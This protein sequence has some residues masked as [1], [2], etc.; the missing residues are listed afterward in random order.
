MH[1]LGI[2]ATPVG[3]VERLQITTNRAL[4][5]SNLSNSGPLAAR[6]ITVSASQSQTFGGIDFGTS[7]A[8]CSVIDSQDGREIASAKT[9]YSSSKPEELA[10]S[11]QQALFA[12]LDAIPAELKADMAAIAID[13]TSATAILFDCQ[14]GS[15]LA[16][17]KLYN[18]A[19]SPHIVDLV[20]SIA[21]KDHTT[22]AATSTL[23][24]LLTWSEAGIWQAA[25]AAGGCPV[26]LHQADWLGFLLHGQCGITDWNNALK[27]G[28]DPEIELYPEWMTNKDFASV[29]PKTVVAPGALV[30]PVSSKIAEKTG[31]SQACVVCGGT[32]DS[33]AAFLAAGVDRPGQAVTSLGSTLAIKLLSESRVD[34][35]AYGV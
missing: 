3:R 21:P 31:L 4:V 17:P 30:A 20:K 23:C 29:L 32:T 33:I 18:E 25:R 24:K 22:V 35:A 12:L 14:H 27:L 1:A 16:T 6:H 28:F 7:G 10:E 2:R 26:I 15:L 5:P 19:Q 8:R 34:N 11:W 9:S 13:G